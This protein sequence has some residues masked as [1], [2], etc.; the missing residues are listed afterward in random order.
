MEV[1]P[2]QYSGFGYAAGLLPSIMAS[3]PDSE[4]P[5]YSRRRHTLAQPI[6]TLSIPRAP[7]EHIYPLVD[8]RSSGK[9][10]ATL[11]IFSSAKSSKSLPTFF[12]KENING[13]FELHAE[14]GDSIQ[15]VTATVSHLATL[16]LGLGH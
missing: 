9:P 15:A 8:G 13:S 7:T 11:K 1:L 14:R 16:L 4:L 6:G 2:P 10:W 5:A 3:G 12:E